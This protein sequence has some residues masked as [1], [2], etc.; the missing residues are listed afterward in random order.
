MI[1]A[2]VT[3]ESMGN[4]NNKKKENSF[5][6]NTE[7]MFRSCGELQLASCQQLHVSLQKCPERLGRAVLRGCYV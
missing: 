1:K 6:F 2:F 4:N 3:S 7:A 5:P